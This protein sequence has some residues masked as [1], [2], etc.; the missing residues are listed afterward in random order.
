M[1]IAGGGLAA[2]ASQKAGPNRSN[3]SAQYR[4]SP[5]DS[6]LNV[7]LRLFFCRAAAIAPSSWFLQ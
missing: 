2:P 3:V 6:F 7:E 5:E 4:D 1:A